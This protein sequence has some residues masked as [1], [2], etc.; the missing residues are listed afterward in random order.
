[1]TL[2]E[3]MALPDV[4]DGYTLSTKVIYGKKVRALTMNPGVGVLFQK[5]DDGVFYTEGEEWETG[6]VG[7]VRVRRRRSRL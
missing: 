3:L 4:G 7:G 5:E 6:W 1:M 2:D